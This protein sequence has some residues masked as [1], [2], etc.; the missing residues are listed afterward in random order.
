[1][2]LEAH[3]VHGD[4]SEYNILMWHGDPII[5]DVGQAVSTYHVNAPSLMMRDIQNVYNF[6]ANFIPAAE[7]K[8]PKEIYHEILHEFHNA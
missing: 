7:M 3:L 2:F 4:L 5:I 6:F 1:M 8:D